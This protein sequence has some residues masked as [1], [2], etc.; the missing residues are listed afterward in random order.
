MGFKSIG[1]TKLD[2]KKSNTKITL[3]NLPVEIRF[4]SLPP[5]EAA[6]RQ[7]KL[8]LLLKGAIKKSKDEKLDS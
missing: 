7:K 8:N 6:Q 4:V 5:A 1:K 2:L 3:K